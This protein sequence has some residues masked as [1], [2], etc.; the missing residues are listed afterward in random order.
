MIPQLLRQRDP[1]EDEL[2]QQLMM[3]YRTGGQGTLPDGYRDETPLAPISRPP[4]DSM[5]SYRPRR[6]P[7]TTIPNA[8][9]A[10]LYGWSGGTQT[11]PGAATPPPVALPPPQAAVSAVAEPGITELPRLRREQQFQYQGPGIDSSTGAPN[12]LSSYAQE[13]AKTEDAKTEAEQ[14]ASRINNLNMLKGIAEGAGRVG[15]AFVEYGDRMAR[16]PVQKA[17]DYTGGIDEALAREEDKI[18][19]SLKEKFKAAGYDLPEGTTFSQFQQFAPAMT[20]SNRNEALSRG[21]SFAREREAGINERSDAAR[22]LREKL[23]ARVSPR[24]AND[25]GDFDDT[26]RL[27]DEIEAEKEDGVASTGW[28][29]NMW[30]TVQ[31][32]FPFVNNPERA[33]FKQKVAFQLNT[34]INTMTGKQMSGPEVARLKAAVPTMSDADEVFMAKV[35]GLRDEVRKIKESRLRALENAGR[36][37]SEFRSGQQQAPAT[38]PPGKKAMMRFPDG[39]VVPVPSE[40]VQAALDAGAVKE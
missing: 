2:I 3:K 5:K 24:D 11:P 38:A 14:R 1:L 29:D 17:R 9:M 21:S 40:H 28:F 4:E 22:A 18:P 13:K 36:D 12:E 19:Q 16:R 15:D 6:A 23:A 30:D 27:L 26:T 37:T 7:K 20:A 35:K 32:S 10:R 33:A 39:E 31:D 34:Y 25:I 8:G